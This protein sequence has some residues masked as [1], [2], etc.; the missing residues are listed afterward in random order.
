MKVKTHRVGAYEVEVNEKGVVERIFLDCERK[1]AYLPVNSKYDN[2]SLI[3]QENIK[4]STFKS[5][6]YKDKYAFFG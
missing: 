6:V 5:Y 1:Y 3:K 4:F 2:T